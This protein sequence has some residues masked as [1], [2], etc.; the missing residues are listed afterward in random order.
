MEENTNL[1]VVV[2][3]G[4]GI[5]ASCCRLMIER[6]WRVVVADINKHAA[7]G[8]AKAIGGFSYALDI[9]DLAAVEE[10][11]AEIEHAHGSVSAMVVAA[12]AFQEIKYSP[13]AFPMDLWQKIIK[14][15][16]EGTFN[17]N[18]VFGARMAR[19]GKGSIVNIASILG[20]ASS[21]QHAY[22]P[23]KAAVLNL[24]R[25]MAAQWGKSGVRVNSVSPGATLVPHVVA[26][27]TGRYATDIDAQMALGRRIQPNEIAE[28]VEFLCS[29]RASA[30]TGTD[31]LIDAGWLVANSWGLYGGIPGPVE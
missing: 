18:R 16:L 21:P 29:D 24:T 25:N 20:H 17:A 22:G 4:N 2:G 5:G 31:L 1:S 26:R 6:G 3:G 8:V 19:K 13:D 28:G 23:T 7:D 30:I 12:A 10:I 15:N 11:A 9:C 27:P 14:V